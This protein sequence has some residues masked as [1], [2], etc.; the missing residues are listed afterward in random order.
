M[1]VRFI[2]SWENIS[3]EIDENEVEDGNLLTKWDAWTQEGTWSLC[4]TDGIDSEEMPNGYYLVFDSWGTG[5]HRARLEKVLDSQQTWIMGIR[6]G[7]WSWMDWLTND[8]LCEVD[9]AIAQLI[10]GSTVQMTLGHDEAGHIK[11][12]RGTITGGTLLATSEFVMNDFDENEYWYGDSPLPWCFYI[13]WK[14]T[15]HDSAG[16]VEVRVTD[17]ITPLRMLGEQ[18]V[19]EISSQDTQV[20]ANPTADTIAICG[21]GEEDEEAY[22]AYDDICVLDGTG[23]EDDD[24]RGDSTVLCVFPN[25]IGDRDDFSPSNGTPKY[26]NVNDQGFPGYWPDGDQTY[27]Y[28]DTPGYRDSYRLTNLSLYGYAVSAIQVCGYMS[29]ADAGGLAAR[30]LIFVAGS[31]YPGATISPKNG[32]Y[33]CFLDLWTKNPVT[34]LA[35]LISEINALEAGVEHALGIAPSVASTIASV[36]APTVVLGSTTA[37]PSAASAVVSSIDPT[38]VIA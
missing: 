32:V 21:G 20:T 3:G 2:E 14:V 19:I 8:P 28:S 33:D 18:V 4:F 11:V 22:N 31:Y 1:A 16:A 37:T 27:N 29:K 38:V 34:G 13:E 9:V 5:P 24:F 23:G 12:W 10:D 15:I 7:P 35:F 25:G 17:Q 26:G 36:V 6:F 30:D